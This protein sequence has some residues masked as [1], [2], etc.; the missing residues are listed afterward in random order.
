MLLD[1]L[2]NIVKES[3][4]LEKYAHD[5]TYS[6]TKSF[7]K[8]TISE[9]ILKVKACEIARNCNYDKYQVLCIRFLKRKQE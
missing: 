1:H 8:R 7:Q 9:K 6:D 5:A 3:K 4:N 2:L